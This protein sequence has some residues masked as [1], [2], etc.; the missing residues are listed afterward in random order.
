MR[1]TCCQFAVMADCHVQQHSLLPLLL[2]LLQQTLLSWLL[3]L[4][5][6]LLR[7]LLGL[8]G[9]LPRRSSQGSWLQQHVLTC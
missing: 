3:P 8:P 4:L 7:V 6:L 2:L 1:L 5:P 9:K